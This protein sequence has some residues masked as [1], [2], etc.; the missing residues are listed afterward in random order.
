MQ[1]M[2][3]VSCTLITREVKRPTID[4]VVATRIARISLIHI[5]NASIPTASIGSV[6]AI[7]V[8]VDPG[9]TVKVF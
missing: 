8:K 9:R 1:G 7:T 2:N 4:I 5:V 6:P 3:T